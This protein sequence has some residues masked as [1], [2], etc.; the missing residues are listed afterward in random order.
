M[1]GRIKID[2]IWG[3]S[4]AGLSYILTHHYLLRRP[5]VC[6]CSGL[7]PRPFFHG[8]LNL[9]NCHKWTMKNLDFNYTVVLEYIIVCSIAKILFFQQSLFCFIDLSYLSLSLEMLGKFAITGGTSMMYAY[10]SELYPTV[11]RNTATGTCSISPRV[12][13]CI[14]PFLFKLSE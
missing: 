1:S 11:L 3:L 13:V 7:K 14:A 8:L 10:V 12:G 9:V 5:Q 4:A 6:P 2:V